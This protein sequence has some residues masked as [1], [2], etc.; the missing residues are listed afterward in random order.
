MRRLHGESVLPYRCRRRPDRARHAVFRPYARWP[1]AVQGL[2]AA[3]PQGRPQDAPHARTGDRI[4]P[5]RPR[6]AH[7]PDGLLQPIYDLPRRTLPSTTWWRPASTPH[8][9]RHPPPEADEELCL[10]AIARG[11]SH[12]PRHPHHRRRAP[13]RRARQHQRL[14]LLR[15]DHGHHRRRRPRSQ[16]R[17]RHVKRIKRSTKL[18]VVVGLASPPLPGQGH[19]G[20][21]RRHSRRICI[22]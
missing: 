16:R 7:H 12:P 21:R 8:H 17:A 6:H 4:P 9:R 20:R 2:L 18:P 13:P 22:G 14:C 1:L 11:L 19:R 10:P 5:A 3:C 15:V